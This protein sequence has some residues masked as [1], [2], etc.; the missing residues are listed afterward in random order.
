MVCSVSLDHCVVTWACLHDSQM[1]IS[2]LDQLCKISQRAEVVV[3]SGNMISS[4]TPLLMQGGLIN[5]VVYPE[6]CTGSE[7]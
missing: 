2:S 7:K 6:Y 5:R 3:V 4:P 1:Y